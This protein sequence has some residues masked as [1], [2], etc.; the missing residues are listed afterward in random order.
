MI[1]YWLQLVAGTGI[2]AIIVYGSI[3]NYPRNYL[4][5]K[6]RII[7]EFLSCS[8]CVGFWSGFIMSH[9]INSTTTQHI[10]IGFSVSACSWLYDSVVGSNQA[11]EVYLLNK[12]EK[13]K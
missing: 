12:I 1:P 9:F 4:K 3:F 10:I 7:N 11:K 5:S 6:A 2:T 13:N 8:M